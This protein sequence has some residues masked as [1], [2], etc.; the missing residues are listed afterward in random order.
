M[1]YIDAMPLRLSSPGAVQASVTVIVPVGLCAML[2]PGSGAGA[3]A[4]GGAVGFES[5]SVPCAAIGRTTPMVRNSM[6]KR[7]RRKIP[8]G[9]AETLGAGGRR[10]AENGGNVR[11]GNGA[12]RPTAIAL[13]MECRPRTR[14]RRDLHFCE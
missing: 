14:R 9:R 6:G 3:G 2:G 12:G 11:R 13:R 10:D 5:I 8:P 7:R 4:G 1:S